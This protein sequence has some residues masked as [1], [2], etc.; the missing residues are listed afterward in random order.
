MQRRG[1]HTSIA[2]EELLG[3]GVFCWGGPSLY[4]EDPRLVQEKELRQS[5]EAVVEDD[6]E[7]KT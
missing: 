3:S 7:E 6:E 5:F 2:I 4:N 1:K